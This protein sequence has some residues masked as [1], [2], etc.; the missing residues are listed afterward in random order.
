MLTVKDLYQIKFGSVTD[1]DSPDDS[2][3]AICD[4]GDAS[5]FITGIFPNF[6]L[7]PSSNETDPGVYA[8]KLT[9]TDTNPEP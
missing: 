8:A 1:P 9:L 2:F 7:N 3:K 5:S 4:F 6:L